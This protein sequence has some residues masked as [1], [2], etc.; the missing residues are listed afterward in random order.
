MR[1]F[2]G[3]TR[4]VPDPERPGLL[5][6]VVPRWM[7]ARWEWTR[8]LLMPFVLFGMGRIAWWLGTRN[9]Y[10]PDTWGFQSRWD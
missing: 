6:R 4:W 9:E 1:F 8:V 7:F 2:I 5:I 10:R 3:P